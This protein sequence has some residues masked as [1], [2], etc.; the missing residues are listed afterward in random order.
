MEVLLTPRGGKLDRVFARFLL[1]EA[2]VRGGSL[3]IVSP[4]ISDVTFER[5]LIYLPYLDAG[6]VLEALEQLASAGKSVFVVTRYYDDVLKPD[7]LYTWAQLFQLL[8]QGS[9]EELDELRRE[10]KDDVSFSLSRIE[11]LDEIL[12]ME[13]VR[14]RFNNRVHAKL[15]VGERLAIIGSANLTFMS[16]RNEEC[17]IVASKDGDGDLY[18]RARE[19]AEEVYASASE[20]RS[21]ERVYL[22]RLQRLE[23]LGLRFSSLESLREWLRELAS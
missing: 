18:R 11:A 23:K 15:Y 4:W 19:Y 8:E 16:T 10:L 2:R 20:E 14:V 17:V 1:E 9:R 22:S 3:Y 7:L 21:Y 5:R 12:R 13:G 6:G